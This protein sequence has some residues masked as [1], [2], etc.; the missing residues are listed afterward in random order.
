MIGETIDCGESMGFSWVACDGAQG[1][2][3]GFEEL[4][5]LGLTL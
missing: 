5:D 3:F 2:V 1:Y 4:R